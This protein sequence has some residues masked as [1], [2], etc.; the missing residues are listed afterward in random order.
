MIIVVGA[1][2]AVAVP[3]NL[4]LFPSADR[5]SRGAAG[6]APPPGALMASPGSPPAS[7]PGAS[8]PG[9]GWG[10]SK[11]H[12]GDGPGRSHPAVRVGPEV[13]V[14]WSLPGFNAEVEEAANP[15]THYIY[16][17]WIAPNGIGFSRSTDGGASFRPSVI[18]PGSEDFS[19]QTTSASSWDPAIATSA[20]GT[21]FA[22]FMYSNSTT[23]PGGA[24]IVDVSYDHGKTFAFSSVVKHTNPSSA[25][26][27]VFLAI[28]P[29]GDIYVTW[30]YSPN[31]SA[32]QYLCSPIGSCG[33]SAGDLNIVFVR[34][35]DRGHTWSRMVSISPGF[36]DGGANSAPLVVEPNGRIDVL[37]QAYHTDR[38]TLALSHGHEY[39]TASTDGGQRWTNPVLV[40]NPAYSASD[41]EWWIDGSLAL[42]S[43]GV[44]YAS[45]DSQHPHGDIGWLQYSPDHGRSWSLPIRVTTDSTG[46]A[47]IIQV[48]AGAGPV[49]Y[50]GWISND[51]R[52]GWSASL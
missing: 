24:P 3:F 50:I 27:R 13:P 26:D 5:P 38:K 25:S 32:I 16:A 11:G 33:F 47:H 29:N 7:M 40:G 48:T 35:S 15:V 36:P 19:N 43:D 49:A 22:A 52:R 9:P 18:V 31:G 17:L 2:L 12:V 37:Y 30:D 6:F 20:N 41:A 46:A 45:Y 44:L 14:S 28:A 1:V 39:F 42:G 10:G 51:S 23:L 34:S 21:V 4:S 8:H